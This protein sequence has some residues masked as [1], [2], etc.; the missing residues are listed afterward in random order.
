MRTSLPTALLAVALSAPAFA[1]SFDDLLEAAA[2]GTLPKQEALLEALCER[3]PEAVEQWRGALAL[4]AADRALVFPEDAPPV[5]DA[6]TLT[7]LHELAEGIPALVALRLE[8]YAAGPRVTAACVALDLLAEHADST[9]FDL[10]LALA[11]PHPEHTL[12]DHRPVGKKLSSCVATLLQRD[13]R[14]YTR[15]AS[16]YG[17]IQEWLDLYLLR[18]LGEVRSAT[19]MRKLASL[20]RVKPAWDATVLL[21]LGNV[22]RHV[23]TPLDDSGARLVRMYLSSHNIEERKQAAITVG[24][25]DDYEAVGDLIDLLAD[26]DRSVRTNA[27]WALREITAMTIN[28]EPRRWRNWFDDETGWWAEQAP[29]LL[30]YFR[31]QDS[32]EVC[33]AINECAKK[34][35]FRRQLTP[36]LLPMLRHREPTVVRA[37]CSAL[38]AL[39]AADVAE[40]MIL[41]LDR[42][43][44]G[45]REHA[46]RMLLG[47]TGLERV[48]PN[49]DAWRAALRRQPS[50]R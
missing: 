20:L 3:G 50:A 37:T 25:L 8:D 34:R 27:Y 18:G 47:L 23:D 1:D 19:S 44:P 21:E 11:K 40:E 4:R 17:N 6:T 14:G 9:S 36:A 10:V 24:R 31:H 13:P 45:V 30:V 48:E 12:T 49:V 42:P 41:A 26:E 33:L 39:R 22:A 43:E 5:L 46:H 29:D 32:A 16:A 38:F 35:L 7:G 15:V 28:A 2:S